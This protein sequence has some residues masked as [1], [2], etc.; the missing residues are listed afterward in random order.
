MELGALV[1]KPF[2]PRAKGTEVRD[3]LGDNIVVKVEVDPTGL[4]YHA[5]AKVNSI[6][7]ALNRHK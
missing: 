2:L 6:I 1:S 3:G 4:H 7:E 5:S